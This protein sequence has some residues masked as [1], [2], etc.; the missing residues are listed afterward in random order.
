[1]E[2]RLRAENI[3]LK[4]SAEGVNLYPLTSEG[5]P[6][7]PE[8]FI[9][10]AEEER[11]AIEEK[12]LRLTREVQETIAQLQTIE[13]DALEKVRELDRSVAERRLDEIFRMLNILRMIMA[14]SEEVQEVFDYLA[15]LKEYTLNSL[16]LFTGGRGQQ[17]SESTAAGT[18][19][20]SSTQRNPWLP[21]E[22]N[23]MAD[24]ADTQ[25]API[26]IESNPTWGNLF[27]RI[28][29]RAYM[30]AYFS[31]HTMLKA[32]STHQAN[33][34]YLLLNARDLLR[35]SCW[36][37]WPVASRTRLTGKPLLASLH[38]L[39][40]PRV[41]GV[42]LDPLSPAQVIDSDLP[43]KA[44]QDDTDLLFRGVLAPSSSLNRSDE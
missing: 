29:R 9:K 42:G 32:G 39:F 19:L 10:M 35:L 44:L 7:D 26:I 37:S 23:V 34:G 2:G 8:E 3:G 20:P 38:D 14:D 5:R 22:V 18:Q 28:E 4:L 21:F 13:K 24:N 6:M 43:A 25:A 17:P 33:S 36:I 15:A 27:G 31:D 30:V 16:N 40:G 41:V 1:M 12:R 11:A